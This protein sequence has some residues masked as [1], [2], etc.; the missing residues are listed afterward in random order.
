MKQ[1]VAVRNCVHKVAQIVIQSRVQ[2]AQTKGRN[3]DFRLDLPELPGL[4]SSRLFHSSVVQKHSVQ[5][6][7]KWLVH[8]EGGRRAKERLT[9]V[10]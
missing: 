6:H 2:E 7:S 1:I 10:V 8:L 5:N 9:T 3:A 4:R